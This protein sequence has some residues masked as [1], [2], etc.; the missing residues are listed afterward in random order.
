MQ[1]CPVCESIVEQE[2]QDYCPN[3]AWEFKH[4]FNKKDK[5]I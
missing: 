5:D 2:S 4:Y 3:C 1:K